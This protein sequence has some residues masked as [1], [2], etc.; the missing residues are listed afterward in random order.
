[1]LCENA[2]NAGARRSDAVRDRKSSAAVL[3]AMPTPTM[4]GR[5]PAPQAAGRKG[6]GLQI[7][8]PARLRVSNLAAGAIAAAS[9]QCIEPAGQDPNLKAPAALCRGTTADRASRRET[10]R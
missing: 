9:V 1:M 4:S 8:A 3:T 5:S 10:E 2:Y 6:C 7:S